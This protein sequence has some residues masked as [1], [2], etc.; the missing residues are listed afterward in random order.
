MDLTPSYSIT[1]LCKLFNLFYICFICKM[2]IIIYI[3]VKKL[4]PN[5]SIIHS[6]NNHPLSTDSECVLFRSQPPL[7]LITQIFPLRNLSYAIISQMIWI[8][9]VPTPKS[10]SELR[11]KP[12]SIPHSPSRVQSFSDG[13]IPNQKQ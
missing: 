8:G 2:Q 13:L 11:L 5:E 1:K 10:R 12:I 6:I 4:L 3:Y 7:P 9:L